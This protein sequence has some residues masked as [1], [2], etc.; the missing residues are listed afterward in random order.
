MPELWPPPED[1]V[2]QAEA[3]LAQVPVLIAELEQ[4]LS[5]AKAHLAELN[6]DAPR[7]RELLTST[8]FEQDRP[9]LAD[10][11]AAQ[12]LRAELVRAAQQSVA[13]SQSASRY[14]QA[15]EKFLQSRRAWT[16]HPEA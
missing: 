14:L 10:L 6:R 11:Q 2:A 4:T 15:R 1:E 8:A 16:A 9:R 13:A 3:M 12:R 7:L 5:R